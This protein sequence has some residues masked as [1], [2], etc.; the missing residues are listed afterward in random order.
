MSKPTLTYFDIPVSRGEECRL[1]FAVAG[2]PFNDERLSREQF[3]A[4]RASFPYGALPVLTV[5][6]KPP[7]AQSNAILRYIG[8]QHGLL[9]NDPWESARHEAVLA[10]VEEM[11]GRL[12]PTNRIKDPEEKKKARLELARDYFPGWAAALEQQITGPFF[13]GTTLSVADLKLYTA[14]VPLLG[15]R[16]DHVSPELFSGYP[17]LNALFAAVKA[18]PKVVAWYAR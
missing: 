18:H 7:L 9:P 10:A 16:V 12:G 13:G 17:K 4:R 1:A 14:L 2:V 6:G 8:S 5:E 3:D 11:R 15:G